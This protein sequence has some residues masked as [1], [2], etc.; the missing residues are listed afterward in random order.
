VTARQPRAHG[1]RERIGSPCVG[2]CE[3]DPGG[4][5]C[6]CRRTLAEIA[7]WITYSTAERDAIIADLD[8]RKVDQTRADESER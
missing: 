6:G 1:G 5:C 2:V 3:L 8:R 7:G 4:H